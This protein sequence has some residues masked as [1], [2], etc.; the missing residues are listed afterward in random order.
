MAQ[1]TEN[2]VAIPMKDEGDGYTCPT[3]KGPWRLD[4]LVNAAC[5]ST[6]T[7]SVWMGTLQTSGEIVVEQPFQPLRNLWL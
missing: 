1:K 2:T 6:L 3:V 7:S 5:A 4:R